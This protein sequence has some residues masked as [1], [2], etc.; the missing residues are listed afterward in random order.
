M[1]GSIQENVILRGSIARI[2]HVVQLLASATPYKTIKC[3]NTCRFACLYK[4]VS[5]SFAIIDRHRSYRFSNSSEWWRPIQP[6]CYEHMCQHGSWW[7]SAW[8]VWVKEEHL[9][10]VRCDGGVERRIKV[11]NNWN[12]SALNQFW[13]IPPE[14]TAIRVRLSHASREVQDLGVLLSNT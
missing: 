5:H 4:L 8:P 13:L 9:M 10:Q 1:K 3:R 12:V 6:A 2:L 11:G 14:N 7:N